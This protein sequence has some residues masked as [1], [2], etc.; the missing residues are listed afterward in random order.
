M[1]DSNVHLD[2]IEN[3]VDLDE[4]MNEEIVE[5]SLFKAYTLSL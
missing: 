1:S 3:Q 4:M 5:L 2:K